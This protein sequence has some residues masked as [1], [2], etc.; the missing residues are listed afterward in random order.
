[1]SGTRNLGL[2][3]GIRWFR[4]T[5]EALQ[6]GGHLWISERSALV[7]QNTSLCPN[8]P[9]QVASMRT[10]CLLWPS[11]VSHKEGFLTPILQMRQLRLGV[12]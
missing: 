11:R 1:M 12:G 5:R 4:P 8:I 3:S 2:A 10:P 9:Q 7:R 6:A